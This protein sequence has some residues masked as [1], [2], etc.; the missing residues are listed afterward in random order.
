MLRFCWLITLYLLVAIVPL[1]ADE[2]ILSFD[3]D[4]TVQADGAFLVTET[5]RVRAEGRQIRRGIFRDFPTVFEDD[6]GRERK[7]DFELISVKRDGR[8]ENA[9]VE[10]GAR[11][12]RIR[13]GNANVFLAEGAYTYE[14][15]YRTDRQLRRFGSHDEVYWNVTGTD[16]AFPIDKASAVVTLPEGG[17]IEDTAYF[18]GPFGAQGKNARRSIA[19]NKRIVA[20]ETSRP[21]APREGLTIAVKFN[22]GVIP[23]PNQQ[24]Q[25]GWFLK[26]FLAEII[27]FGGLLVVFFYYLWAWIRV[28]RDPPKDAMVPRWDLPDGIS[29]AL[30]HYIHFKGL[31]KQG[32]TAL[33]AAALSLAVKGHITLDN[34]DGELTVNK[35]PDF[36]EEALPVGE[37]AILSRINGRGGSLKINKANGSA[38]KTLSSR[39]SSAISG[40]HRSV[41]YKHNAG[42]IVAGVALS[43]ATFIAII[44]SGGLSEDIIVFIIPV[45][46]FGSF[47]M[48]ITTTIARGFFAGG[49]GAKVRMVFAFFFGAIFVSQIGLG[50]ALSFL[51]DAPSHFLLG[52]LLALVMVNVLFF[53]LMGAPT[54]LGQKRNAEI[55]GLKHYLS[56]AE[57]DRMNMLGSPEM[58]PQHYETLLPYAVALGVEKPWSKA[59][60]GWL[61]AA[62]AAGTAAAVAYNGPHWYGGRRFS[63]DT[64][65]DTLGSI[66]TDLASSMTSS[67]PA[68]KSSSS[69]FSGGGGSSGG[70]GGGGGG[71]GW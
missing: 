64:I 31:Q 36:P 61:A 46:V 20:F 10:T 28:G 16:W 23:E 40:E 34:D 8:T 22:K 27:A 6:N 59:F 26:D 9:A 55:E 63:P 25:L 60:Q 33:S 47:F 29:P 66:G 65:G 3:S 43:I 42:Y 12:L 41:F 56:V 18:T 51:S 19:S 62:V 44:F 1:R 50:T 24:Q 15:V 4:I 48:G 37:A 49:L 53:F 54:P 52:A 2:R 5:I 45:V 70:G 7:V 39:F 71:G 30:A 68:P 38:I 13:I 11:A 67:M 35:V 14:I 58:S 69:G 17:V 21:L 32:F 57:E